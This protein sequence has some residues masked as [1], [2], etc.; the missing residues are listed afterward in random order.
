MYK[1]AHIKKYLF[2]DNIVR[3]GI[4]YFLSFILFFSQT[5]NCYAEGQIASDQ[6][7]VVHSESVL[8]GVEITTAANPDIAVVNIATPSAA[9]VSYNTYDKFNVDT[10][11]VI[12]NNS[13][14]M[15]KTEIGGQVLAN[16]N[17]SDGR[18]ADIII[19]HVVSHNTSTLA[20]PTEIAGRKAAYILANPNGI[21]I[22]GA[23][24]INA[25][26]ATIAT[27]VPS[28]DS[29]GGL[30]SIIVN[31][32]RVY[33]GPEDLDMTG[34]DYFDIVAKTVEVAS[35]IHAKE[36]KIVTGNNSYDYDTR[37]VSKNDMHEKK[38][39]SVAIDSSIVGGLYAD[40]ITIVATKDGAGIKLPEISVKK[41]MKITAD[42]KIIHSSIQGEDIE[43]V[44]KKSSVVSVKDS[45]IHATGSYNVSAKDKVKVSERSSISSPTMKISGDVIDNLGT[46]QTSS[47][48]S[49]NESIDFIAGTFR[50]AGKVASVAGNISIE[51]TGSLQNHGHI[52]ARILD[53]R[54]Q[55][56]F[57][58]FGNIFAE[59][60][61]KINSVGDV[62]NFEN[63][64]MF[65]VLGVEVNTLGHFENHPLAYVVSRGG[66]ASIMSIGD[67]NNKG[68]IGVKEELHV[69][70]GT[71]FWNMGKIV[72]DSI[73]LESSSFFNL[74][75]VESRSSYFTTFGDFKNSAS[76]ISRESFT[77]DSRNIGNSG[78]LKTDGSARLRSAGFINNISSGDIKG[79]IYAGMLNIDSHD[80]NSD[81]YIVASGDLLLS[82]ANLRN[83]G[84][85]KAYKIVGVG[86][87]F[88]HIVNMGNIQ[89]DGDIV[90]SSNLSLLNE[91]GAIYSQSFIDLS[92]KDLRNVSSG[93]IKGDLGMLLTA[94]GRFENLDKA[95]ILSGG[96][97]VNKSG[98]FINDSL[99]EGREIEIAAETLASN[100][101]ELKSL[102]E[103]SGILI[104]GG[105]LRNYGI[106]AAESNIILKSNGA[107]TSGRGGSILSLNGKIS[108]SSESLENDGL[109][110]ADRFFI[111]VVG[112]V[113]NRGRLKSLTEAPDIVSRDFT[114][115][116]ELRF[117]GSS[118]ILS[119][120]KLEN[121]GSILSEK[122]SNINA[123]TIENSA[124]EK[125]ES[126]ESTILSEVKD[127]VRVFPSIFGTGSFDSF[128]NFGEIVSDDEI[129]FDVENIFENSGDKSRITSWLPIFVT[130]GRFVNS[131]GARLETS[132]S[133]K[134]ISDSAIENSEFSSISAS[135]SIDIGAFNI[136]NSGE[137]ISSGG[138]LFDAMELKNKGL[139][140]AGSKI[141]VK[142][143]AFEE[144]IN[145]GKIE[146]NGDIVLSSRF[147]ILNQLS[148]IIN[149][150]QGYTNLSSRDIRNISD[151]LISGGLGV[152]LISENIVENSFASKI[153]SNNGITNKSKEFINNGVMEGEE[154]SISV[155]SLVSNA[156]EL[157]GLEGGLDI[158]VSEGNLA[159]SGVIRA[160][161]D[162]NLFIGKSIENSSEALIVSETGIINEKSDYLG[163]RGLIKAEGLIFDVEN[164][165]VNSST[166]KFVSLSGPADFKSLSLTNDGE[167]WLKS[168]HFVV[169]Q[170]FENSGFVDSEES[171]SVAAGDIENS[172]ILKTHG[173][174][175][176]VS[177]RA[178]KNFTNGDKIGAI[179]GY[180]SVSLESKT[181]FN[182][183]MIRSAGKIYSEGQ[184][185]NFVNAGEIVS[186]KDI[187][188]SVTDDL[189]N[190]GGKIISSLPLHVDA[191][192]IVNLEGGRLESI[193]SCEIHSVNS[194]E[195]SKSSFIG[196]KDFLKLISGND[197]TNRGDI[198]TK[199]GLS[200]SGANLS[201]T[202]TIHGLNV[203]TK[204]DMEVESKFV[205]IVNSDG[206]SIEAENE[207]VL[208][209]SR[210]I[211]N[212]NGMIY[213]QGSTNLSSH[214]IR[215]ISGG[216]IV[217]AKS[218]V[219]AARASIKNLYGSIISSGETLDLSIINGGI[220]NFGTFV[221]K[222]NI[223]LSSS[224]KVIN[225]AEGII[226]STFGNITANS[227]SLDNR[228]VLEAQGLTLMINDDISNIG[229]LHASAN[230]LNIT[231]VVGSLTNSGKIIADN[232][233][234]FSIKTQILNDVSGVINLGKTSTISSL[235]LDITNNGEITVVDG[236][237][238]LSVMRKFENAGTFAVN[239]GSLELKVGEEIVNSKNIKVARDLIFTNLI[240]GKKIRNIENRATGSIVSNAD[241]KFLSALN[242]TNSGTLE[243][244][245]K[246]DVDTVRFE[247]LKKI[248]LG[249]TSAITSSDI[250]NRGE[251]SILNGDMNLYEVTKLENA[252]VIRVK[253]GSLGVRAGNEV[254]N[255]GSIEVL[256]N[257]TISNK[258]S[259]EIRD[260]SN[261]ETGIILVG[262]DMNI[263]LSGNFTNKGALQS[264]GKFNAG[265]R[266]FRN[267]GKVLVKTM[268]I[269]SNIFENTGSLM[270]LDGGFS[271]RVSGSFMNAGDIVVTGLTNLGIDGDVTNSK[272]LAFK[273]VVEKLLVGGFR[274]S[275]LLRFDADSTV[276]VSRSFDN[277][278][279][280]LLYGSGRKLH[281]TASSIKSD[282][283]MHLNSVES[284]VLATAGNIEIANLASNSGN[285][286]LR[287]ASSLL[288]KDKILVQGGLTIGGVEEIPGSRVKLVEGSGIIQ[289]GGALNITTEAFKLTTPA[290]KL[291][292]DGKLT[293]LTKRLENLGTIFAKNMDMVVE[294]DL[295]DPGYIG[296]S[297]GRV[298]VVG[299]LTIPAGKVV[300]SSGDLDIEARDFVHRGALYTRGSARVT[301]AGDF[302]QNGVIRSDGGFTAILPG[303]SFVSG[304]GS[305]THSLGNLSISARYVNNQGSGELFSSSD[306][307]IN[308]RDLI[309]YGTIGAGGRLGIQAETSVIN[310]HYLQGSF[311]D[312]GA[313]N[314]VNNSVVLARGDISLTGYGGAKTGSVA[315]YGTI[316]SLYSGTITV[317]SGNFSNNNPGFRIS[318]AKSS[319]ELMSTYGLPYKKEGASVG[320]IRREIGLLP[321]REIGDYVFAYKRDDVSPGV[322]A[323]LITNGS[324]NIDVLGRITNDHSIIAAANTVYVSG[325]EL[326]NP[327]EAVYDRGFKYKEYSYEYV[328]HQ[329]RSGK[330]GQGRLHDVMASATA[331]HVVP[332]EEVVGE[333]GYSAGGSIIRARSI[334]GN[335]A[336]AVINSRAEFGP[337]GYSMVAPSHKPPIAPIENSLSAI[338]PM[339]PQTLPA[340]IFAKMAA[341][342]ITQAATFTNP[343]VT[344]FRSKLLSAVN[345]EIEF[346]PIPEISFGPSSGIAVTSSSVKTGNSKSGTSTEFTEVPVVIFGSGDGGSVAGESN[347]SDADEIDSITEILAGEKRAILNTNAL[348]IAL[349][350]APGTYDSSGDGEG[351][352]SELYSLMLH[353]EDSRRIHE[354]ESSESYSF[355]IPD[356][357]SRTY[358]IETNPD[359]VNA[360]RFLASRRMPEVLQSTSIS[361]QPESS[362]P[363][364]SHVKLVRDQISN[365]VGSLDYGKTNEELMYHLYRNADHEAVRLGLVPGASISHESVSRLRRNIVWHEPITI[366][367]Q[368]KIV[369]KVYLASGQTR[370]DGLIADEINISAES[371][372]N[373]GNIRG[374]NVT[375]LSRSG[376]SNLGGSIFAS[377]YMRLGA[378]GDIVNV[379]GTIS[380]LGSALFSAENIFNITEKSRESSYDGFREKLG[381][382]STID[383]RGDVRSITSG[384]Q[385]HHASI[386]MAGNLSMEAGGDIKLSAHNIES[387]YESGNDGREY[388]VVNEGSGLVVAGSAFIK[389]DGDFVVDASKVASGGDIEVIA[390]GGVEVRAGIDMH[391]YEASSVSSKRNNFG[392]KSSKIST[393]VIHSENL[394]G[395]AIEAHG[396]F[397]VFAGDGT[398]MRGANIVSGEGARIDGGRVEILAA[399]T[400]N[401]VSSSTSYRDAAWQSVKVSERGGNV[402]NETRFEGG[403]EFGEVSGGIKVERRVSG[404]D[405]S[406][407]NESVVGKAAAGRDDVSVVGISDEVTNTNYR[408][409]GL[410]PEASSVLSVVAGSVTSGI[411]SGLGA[412]ITGSMGVS[413]VGSAVIS[414]GIRAGVS[415]LSSRFVVSSVNNRGDIGKGLGEVLSKEG[416]RAV[417][418]S[419][420]LGGISSGVDVVSKAALGGG[421][422]FIRGSAV[423]GMRVGVKSVVSSSITGSSIGDSLSGN[424]V[425]EGTDSAFKSIGDVSSLHGIRDG[426]ALK[427]AMHGAVGGLSS[428]ASGGRFRDG[429][430]GGGAVEGLSGVIDRVGGSRVGE[431]G[432]V[433]SSRE[434]RV[435]V[436][437]SIGAISSFVGGGSVGDIGAA[438]NVG[439][440]GRSNN[441]ELHSD[442][443]QVL[444]YVTKGMGE[445]ERD[446]YEKAAKYLVHASGGVSEEE[447]QKVGLIRDEREGSGYTRE[448][449]ELRRAATKL[450]KVDL[451][452]YGMIDRVDDGLSR[453]DEVVSRGIGAMEVVI[454]ARG[455][456]ASAR[457]G[458]LVG[459]SMGGMMVA[460]GYEKLEGEYESVSGSRVVESF[461]KPIGGYY[462]HRK[463]EEVAYEIAILSALGG[464]GEGVSVAR[465]MLSSRSGAR[466]MVK[467]SG[468]YGP[469]GVGTRYAELDLA[470]RD[471]G[472]KG[473]EFSINSSKDLPQISPSVSRGPRYTY[474]STPAESE[475][476]SGTIKIVDGSY[477]FVAKQKPSIIPNAR[478]PK[479]AVEAS[480]LHPSGMMVKKDGAG[481]V[482]GVAYTREAVSLELKHKPGT[483]RMAFDKKVRALDDLA[484]RGKLYKV[485]P[486]RTSMATRAYRRTIL[487]KA[488]KKFMASEPEKFRRIQRLIKDMDVDHLHEL[489][490]GGKD[491]LSEMG[492]LDK[493]VNRSIGVQVRHQIEPYSVGTRILRVMEKK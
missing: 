246:F 84:L 348:N 351:K 97:I 448:Q 38:E 94:D 32:G 12:I 366:G 34:L 287:T 164:G 242:I 17:F 205:Q 191:G 435:G 104:S 108:I 339:P 304:W 123:E 55:Q 185:N 379:G 159:N 109:I 64:S 91:S 442:E 493:A 9:G 2:I 216:R 245:G 73:N 226:G 465:K 295:L 461:K 380:G 342:E 420:L 169:A 187:F 198:I 132:A 53:V 33:M 257:F 440:S 329:K 263:P 253:K 178:I 360:D 475:L 349:M 69:W 228:G 484:E 422:G 134:I 83:T 119:S 186:G 414:S 189:V 437:S 367:N 389:A 58:N 21:S 65:G 67:F 446:R 230:L 103:G 383:F 93:L 214:D 491:I 486:E 358:R 478:V 299:G 221:A 114:N 239:K 271:G 81:G 78:V 318:H 217:S 369:P 471:I 243:V 20:G 136:E 1:S 354:I 338:T 40:R 112:G 356:K 179:Y 229:T 272:M 427:V 26:S 274:N 406:S 283:K 62:R 225:G 153:L 449:V 322:P 398:I 52:S 432:G 196:A 237:M 157:R 416:V 404:N 396:R 372:V 209:S 336:R 289:S 316:E 392:V 452:K 431:D 244:L 434:L 149:S 75:E 267:E 346:E 224:G 261:M 18:T 110:Q 116:G 98:K 183:G 165:L 303:H 473:K 140:S 428:I 314:I 199:G 208:L 166:G 259:A 124:V 145:S 118:F 206:G 68:L 90:L 311:V 203:K 362:L 409:S 450:G 31:S 54:T 99:I 5:Y 382:V 89:A 210:E 50:N 23:T 202:G 378:A 270:V 489:Q 268:A 43:I 355:N 16:P 386:L 265:A 474:I 418:S 77:I 361:M 167:M 86:E 285:I 324:I 251:I 333:R 451:F 3:R 375:L 142:P 453:N 236:N 147:L 162:I 441:R 399:K 139:L 294:S 424:V 458:N 24:F 344:A 490:L 212:D 296:T 307:I 200:L 472:S 87:K 276:S 425:M 430:I 370:I 201:N 391:H 137:I 194:I 192:K 300:T 70:S 249:N 82:G 181:F 413:G 480:P 15:V 275:E 250:I 476:K 96:E 195:N 85:L 468:D 403:L 298:K 117:K 292:S 46:I 7:I 411:G 466:S 126:T 373:T 8:H 291:L 387:R 290:S 177:E 421:G 219:L 359:Y 384:D 48:S 388:H 423:S 327:M 352:E 193:T 125:S 154:I 433:G 37:S 173:L 45:K 401:M 284:K 477:E 105:D 323:H 410:T 61:L 277:A 238:N 220:D 330:W 385:L 400:L 74:G 436:A 439:G 325:T 482:S 211:L 188:F 106:I 248:K 175:T 402:A 337:R 204:L 63:A 312:I 264:A 39:K 377:K 180:E 240:V 141:E 133:F 483:N 172:G 297:G 197:I 59:D 407:F 310:S 156:G 115:F 341:D 72:A 241:V 273:G 395:G 42:G 485:E 454:G 135:E 111:N 254:I 397:K 492:L 412:T 408:R 381:R 47:V 340:D 317:R 363:D 122:D 60:R 293:L 331:Y 309:N 129:I 215:N 143:E 335:L 170:S 66:N 222:S 353:M 255:R 88:E 56:E 49:G 463:T 256:K 350:E 213:S 288:V 160:K 14:T 148:G 426:S 464:A 128:T 233:G 76:I 479:P 146:A 455:V 163:N 36:I 315:N 155:E 357:P 345:R 487:D 443:Q 326:I 469:G 394:S 71:E 151:G 302:S 4:C 144:I 138:L 444:M 174:A 232:G 182:D 131:G 223:V 301:L 459:M 417:G 488:E 57:G 168:S 80:I 445:E 260:I 152:K 207:L 25:A 308:T 130:A 158:T 279:T 28:I 405:N 19:N 429:A 127:T 35:R 266:K 262:G 107:I 415:A 227:K 79:K 176:L 313:S 371:I 278:G 305:Q 347:V 6:G 462:V 10:A 374:S 247:N 467:V 218:A 376:I 235:N 281:L 101:G 11:G 319:A 44:S 22:D 121:H 320:G 102:G 95:S 29:N 368:I 51:A 460:G 280:G 100:S 41:E 171:L 27:G 234:I 286:S 231:T 438:S 161:S 120:S 30:E 364:Y 92:S 269:S 252:G 390:A 334:A 113:V 258:T 447:W 470:G 13:D 456:I 328:H 282:G 393:S 321:S 150:K 184:F 481:N 332:H 343:E 457:R 365:L 306:I 190:R 419:M